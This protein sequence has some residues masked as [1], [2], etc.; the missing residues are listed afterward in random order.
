MLHNLRPK[1]R[2]SFLSPHS[3]LRFPLLPTAA[4][5]SK[6]QQQQQQQKLAKSSSLVSGA[7]A[8]VGGLLKPWLGGGSK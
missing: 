3:C 1:K 8:A 5:D 4:D 6:Q 2:S 7:A